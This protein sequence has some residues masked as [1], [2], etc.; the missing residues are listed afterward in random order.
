MHIVCPSHWLADCARR[1]TLMAHLPITVIPN[2]L[3]LTVWAPCDQTHARA[4]VGLPAERPLMLFGAMGGSADPRKGADLLLGALK[5]LRHQV[6]FT[7][8]QQ[9]ELV[10][11][12]QSRPAQPPDLGF[13]IHTSGPCTTTSACACSM[14]P[15]MCS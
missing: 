6:T 12:G 13:P 9:L 15:P 11:F 7:P 8:L 5:Y 2:P 10:R 3:D 4:L 14:P 1:S